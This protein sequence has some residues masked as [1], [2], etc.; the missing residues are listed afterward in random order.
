MNDPKLDWKLSEFLKLL[1]DMLAEMVMRPDDLTVTVEQMPTGYDVCINC[2]GR[3][4]GRMI[5]SGGRRFKALQTLLREYGRNYGLGL[6]LRRVPE[7]KDNKTD[8]TR[9]TLGSNQLRPVLED[10]SSRLL[11]A[12]A[13]YHDEASVS[14]VEEGEGEESRFVVTVNLSEREPRPLES[15]MREVFGIFLEAVT[16]INKRSVR[17]CFVSDGQQP[18]HAHGRYADET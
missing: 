13:R 10:I 11:K 7:K 5:G 8:P 17:V 14:V 15:A 9:V 2:A 3:D 1:R 6:Y 16:L 4:V 12:M 18:S